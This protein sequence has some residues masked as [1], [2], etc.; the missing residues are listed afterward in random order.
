MT[1]LWLACH[2]SQSD[3]AVLLLH[4]GADPNIAATWTSGG[5]ADQ[6]SPLF[7]AADSGDVSLVRRLVERGA[8]NSLGISPLSA[9]GL[10]EE[11]R[12]ILKANT[13]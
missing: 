1:P 7:W 8:R 9:A 6:W 11:I 12:I 2:N 5:I 10:T 13:N 3:A 4:L